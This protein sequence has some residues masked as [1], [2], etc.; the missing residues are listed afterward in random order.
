MTDLDRMDPKSDLV[1]DM[2]MVMDLVSAGRDDLALPHLERLCARQPDA[3]DLQWALARCSFFLGH[4]EAALAV[5]DQAL[6]SDPDGLLHGRALVRDLVLSDRHASAVLL[7]QRLGGAP[8]GEAQRWAYEARRVPKGVFLLVLLPS[9]RFGPPV[10]VVLG[11]T[12]WVLAF[13]LIVFRAGRRFK[14][15]GALDRLVL[16]YVIEAQT[17]S[18]LFR[19]RRRDALALVGLAV[20]CFLAAGY[21]AFAPGPIPPPTS[22]VAAIGGVGLFLGSAGMLAFR[23]DLIR[24]RHYREVERSRSDPFAGDESDVPL[25]AADVSLEAQVTAALLPQLVALRRH[26]DIAEAV[27]GI[28]L[29]TLEE[30]LR[31]QVAC[32]VQLVARSLLAQEG[33]HQTQR[34]LD[35]LSQA[36]LASP[37]DQ[38]LLKITARIG[39]IHSR[40]LRKRAIPDRV[41]VPEGVQLAMR[42]FPRR[43]DARL[44]IFAT[45]VVAIVAAQVL[46]TIA[47]AAPSSAVTLPLLFLAGLVW[48]TAVRR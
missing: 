10:A 13:E 21:G 20:G 45:L 18:G 42:L 48:R 26:H 47:G 4:V 43:A 5:C 46:L 8:V 11:V 27:R 12:G 33:K 32:S 40:R 28:D 34:A 22:L 16:M 2:A 23:R 7:Y 24:R 35:L 39:R 36:F 9:L 6:S 15:L 41:T 37:S 1:A 25:Q 31:S 14:D 38:E 29:V 30:P 44:I 17:R 3:A 19:I